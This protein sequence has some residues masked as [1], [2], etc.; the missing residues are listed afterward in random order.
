M[1]PAL[2]LL[3]NLS[4]SIAAL[5]LASRDNI[6]AYITSK[7]ANSLTVSRLPNVNTAVP[8]T[9]KA[10]IAKFQGFNEVN[11]QACLIYQ[12]A[13]AAGLP[14]D[15]PTLN[16]IVVAA[17]GGPAG[18]VG[19]QPALTQYGT[20]NHLGANLSA[21]SALAYSIQDDSTDIDPVLQF[22]P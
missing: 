17:W 7:Y 15:G 5:P 4:A 21:L 10:I 22:T 6:Q 1:A 2:S 20:L 11:Y 12:L 3:V 9:A 18:V 8:A 14:T 13:L 16:N 19:A